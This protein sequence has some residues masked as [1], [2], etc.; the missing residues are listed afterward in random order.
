MSTFLTK[1][2][3]DRKERRAMQARANALPRDYRIVYGAVKSY[4]WMFATRR[5]P[6]RARVLRS[7]AGNRPLP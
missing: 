2:L 6:D 3:G 5:G 4:L 7:P 1:I